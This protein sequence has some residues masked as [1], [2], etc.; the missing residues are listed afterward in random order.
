MQAD[1]ATIHE[2]A[3]HLAIVLLNIEAS[4]SGPYNSC[5]H[6]A[7]IIIF[8]F[9]L[10]SLTTC[11]MKMCTVIPKV[12]MLRISTW[13]SVTTQCRRTRQTFV[14]LGIGS[15][16]HLNDPASAKPRS[17]S[18]A[19]PTETFRSWCGKRGSTSPLMLGGT[20][21]YDT[22][23]ILARPADI[24][25]EVQSITF[26]LDANHTTVESRCSSFASAE[27]SWRSSDGCVH[28]P[29]HRPEKPHGFWP[30]ERT[31]HSDGPFCDCVV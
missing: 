13:T 3:K 31:V 14:A 30:R 16:G 28:V 20:T 2:R 4:G 12:S 10:T 11:N 18:G 5:H 21:P 8:M 1:H 7:I 23:L 25:V 19:M 22:A 26:S 15:T 24:Q 6:V 9:G 29:T 17:W 27:T